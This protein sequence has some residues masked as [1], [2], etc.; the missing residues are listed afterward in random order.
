MRLPGRAAQSIATKG[1]AARAAEIVNGARRDLLACACVAYDQQVGVRAGHRA[2]PVAQINHSLRAAR[3]ARFKIVAFA[4]NGAQFAVFQH[5]LP[6]IHGAP[7]H[8]G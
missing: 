1:C 3:Q 8:F 5:K 7:R 6:A 4:G 2:Q